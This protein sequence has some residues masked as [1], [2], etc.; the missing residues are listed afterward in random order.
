MPDTTLRSL[1][2][3]K[4]D[5]TSPCLSKRTL[6]GHHPSC[7]SFQDMSFVIATF[8]ETRFVRLANFPHA[9]S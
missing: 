5:V 2:V 4:L 7:S 6:T 9:L 3:T 1:Q 8:L